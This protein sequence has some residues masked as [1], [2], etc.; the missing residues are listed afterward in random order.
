MPPN[1]APDKRL[2]P[3]LAAQ[4]ASLKASSVDQATIDAVKLH[5]LDAL[6][7]TW[8]GAETSEIK[9]TH[10]AL[11]HAAFA[12]VRAKFAGGHQSL[13]DHPTVAATMLV[14]ACR[15]TECDDIHIGCCVTPSS[16]VVPVALVAAQVANA[17]RDTV[18]EGILAGYQ[19]MLTL[20]LAARGAEIIY[21]GVWTTYL[22]GGIAAAAIAAKIMGLNETQI[23]DAMA[24]AG[25]SATGITGRIEAEPAP[26]WFVL[27]TAVQ[28]G[29]LAA[30][31]AAS[32]MHG[33]E[34]ILGKVSPVWNPE[35]IALPE[36]AGPGAP[37]LASKIGFKPYCTSRQGLSATEAFI[38]CIKRDKIDPASIEKI[39]IEVPQ[40]YRDMI[41]RNK[42]P[43]TKSESRGI[44]YQVALGALHPEELCDIER[45]H[46]RADD[47]AMLHVMDAVEVIA[48]ERLSKFYPTQWGGKVTI[49]AGGKT[50]EHEVLH[51]HGDPENPMTA[52]EI[53]TKLETMSRFLKR[54]I[55]VKDYAK[56]AQSLDLRAALPSLIDAVSR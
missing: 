8:A 24:I 21:K 32:G 50:H 33:D 22:T 18:I 12:S 45:E 25:S 27:A 51:P 47:P 5:A 2:L 16:V 20:G 46:V 23:R 52:G 49:K 10:A 28:S 31:A 53:E 17:P 11:K 39:T 4:I 40:Q 44:H 41:D 29:L 43:K 15:L 35:T 19:T 37:L 9:P 13:L 56:A 38:E 54:P 14:T 3:D 6:G 36:Q 34:A 42:R 48:S 55:P 26:R 30:A 1:S 7:C